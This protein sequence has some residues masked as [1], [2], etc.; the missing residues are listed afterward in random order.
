MNEIYDIG[1]VQ[2]RYGYCCFNAVCLKI[3]LSSRSL[4]D[5]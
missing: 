5:R 2:E 4:R 1:N 3:N